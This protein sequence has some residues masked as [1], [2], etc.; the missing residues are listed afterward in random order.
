MCNE[1]VANNRKLQYANYGQS[2]LQSDK[3]RAGETL[4]IFGM[5]AVEAGNPISDRNGGPGETQKGEGESGIIESTAKTNSKS[6]DST[7]L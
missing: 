4:F 2:I 7:L 6:L 3:K 1:V 5:E